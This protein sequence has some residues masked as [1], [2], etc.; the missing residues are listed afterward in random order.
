V[1]DARD[2]RGEGQDTSRS[3]HRDIVNTTLMDGSVRGITS[4]I[5]LST[6][7]ALGS[8]AGGEPIAADY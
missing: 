2:G 6:W 8:R 4:A 7:R 3:H 1:Q 5:E